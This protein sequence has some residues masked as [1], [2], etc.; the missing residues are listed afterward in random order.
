MVFSLFLD[1]E[2]VDELKQKI[3]NLTAQ[4]NAM[5]KILFQ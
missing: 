3:E 1:P 2:L 5:R 4:V